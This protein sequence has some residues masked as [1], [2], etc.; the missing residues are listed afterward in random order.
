VAPRAV[1]R[2]AAGIHRAIQARLDP[3]IGGWT[4]EVALERAT[5]TLR[6]L[7][8]LLILAPAIDGRSSSSPGDG[9]PRDSLV[10]Q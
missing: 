8:D 2:A 4:G 3:A 5:P 7:L 6:E 1:S 10:P 9:D